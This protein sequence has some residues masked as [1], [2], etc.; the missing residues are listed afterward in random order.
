MAFVPLIQRLLLPSGGLPAVLALG[1]V[2][3]ALAALILGGRLGPRSIGCASVL[4]GIGLW[5]ASSPSPALA[6][7]A[8]S[9]PEFERLAFEE[10]ANFAVTVVDDQLRSERT[11]L[12]DD[13]R[14]TATG[15]DYLYM[16]ALGHVPLL[17]HPA[18]SQTGVL[19]FGTGTT[20]GAVALHPEVDSLRILE[21]SASVLDFAPYFEE[22]N[23][24]VL[25]DPRVQVL[26][27]DG[28]RSLGGMPQGLDVLT[29]EPLLPDSPFGVYLYT[30]EFYGTVRRALKPGGLLCQWVPPHALRPATFDAVIAAFSGG[31]SWSGVFLF[32]TQVLLVGGDRE[33]Q[34]DPA[35]FP[36]SGPAREA[37]AALGM[38]EP[39]GLA[40]RFVCAGWPAAA[41]P[42]TD[43]D[44]WVLFEPKAPGLEVLGWLPGNLATLRGRE[45]ALP[46][47]WAS[48]CGKAGAERFAGVRELHRAREAFERTRYRLP[49][50]EGLGD[51]A[52]HAGRA[53]AVL[54][55]DPEWLHLARVASFET[56]RSEG[57]GLLRAG[58]S[59]AALSKLLA[60]A[61]QRPERADVHLFV[62]LAA[63]GAGQQDVALAAL[64]RSLEQCPRILETRPGRLA[65]GIGF[66]PRL[67]GA[68]K[69]MTTRSIGNGD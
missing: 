54:G 57:L 42:L 38:S 5:T 66:S 68:L 27:G 45:Q 28:R 64:G 65:V 53:A 29:M 37:L 4:A 47:A 12:T 51:F 60:A 14:A 31:F 24:G 17:L 55:D 22:V 34:L 49:G 67:V 8:L 63:D 35:R 61:E 52:S 9:R 39:S 21:L 46:A 48:V 69:R 40:S 20:A 2:L 26:V 13:F 32:G 3:G 10:D 1:P 16:R 59:R 62:A 44:P 43:A 41:R 23:G 6:S 25:S 11:L 15:D 30:A 7:A 36:A 19:A 33:P 56:R 58:Q 50:A 18:P